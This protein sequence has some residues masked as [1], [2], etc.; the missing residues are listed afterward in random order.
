MLQPGGMNTAGWVAFIL[1]CPPACVELSHYTLYP[2]RSTN[3][4][5][6]THNSLKCTEMWAINLR[7]RMISRS[8]GP[9]NVQ[10][11]IALS[12]SRQLQLGHAIR[13]NGNGA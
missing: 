13:C 10:S 11:L 5:M 7:S 6:D 12:L 8:H 3:M 1:S 4:H 2:S 9:Y